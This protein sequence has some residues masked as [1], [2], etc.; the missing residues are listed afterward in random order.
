MPGLIAFLFVSLSVQTQSASASTIGTSA[1][2]LQFLAEGTN[3]MAQRVLGKRYAMGIEDVDQ[4]INKAVF[5]LQKAA[6]KGDAEAQYYLGKI[7]HHALQDLVQAHMWFSL[8]KTQ[9]KGLAE[10]AENNRKFTEAKMTPR[11]IEEAQVLASE[12]LAK[13]EQPDQPVTLQI[14]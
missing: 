12:W 9:R 5:W 1:K 3:T 6:D 8:I 7:Y 10:L 2:D 14:K 11:Q 13:H 4:D